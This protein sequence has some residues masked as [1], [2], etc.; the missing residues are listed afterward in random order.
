MRRGG[1]RRA[2]REASAFRVVLPEI[3]WEHANRAINDDANQ[4]Y[5]VM[6]K[7]HSTIERLIRRAAGEAIDE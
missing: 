2:C 4:K 6:G 3:R 7:E 5:A 1:V